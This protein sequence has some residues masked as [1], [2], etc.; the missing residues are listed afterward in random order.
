MQYRSI[1]VHCSMGDSQE[2]KRS[3]RTM[4]QPITSFRVFPDNIRHN[5]TQIVALATQS[6]N[7]GCR[8]ILLFS[9]AFSLHAP[10]NS[11]GL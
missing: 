2:S 4:I 5:H 10:G 11:I 1:T 8:G 3:S 9:L 6:A 7:I